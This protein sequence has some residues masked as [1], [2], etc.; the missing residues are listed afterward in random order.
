LDR[1]H[2]PVVA[3]PLMMMMM[4]MQPKVIGAFTL[5]RGL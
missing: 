3:A 4:M 1:G 2:Q 5:R